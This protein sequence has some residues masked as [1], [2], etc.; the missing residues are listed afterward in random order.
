MNEIVAANLGIN[1]SRTLAQSAL[2]WAPV[3]PDDDDERA[4]IRSMRSWSAARL[5]GLARGTYHLA[6]RV[7]PVQ[8]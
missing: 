3:V 8:L 2:P 5:R 4:P 1:Q 7:D 6:N